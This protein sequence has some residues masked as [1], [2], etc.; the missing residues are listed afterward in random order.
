MGGLCKWLWF[1][2]LLINSCPPNM[3]AYFCQKVTDF[4]TDHEI[5]EANVTMPRFF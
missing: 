5:S 2:P 1:L 4:A 3:A